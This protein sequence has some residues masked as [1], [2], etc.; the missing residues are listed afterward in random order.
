[1]DSVPIPCLNCRR[2]VT[3]PGGLVRAARKAETEYIVFCSK[4]CNVVYV[5][6]EGARGQQEEES[7]R[8]SDADF[9]E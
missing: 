5:A 6:T 8:H 7:A 2:L 1:M 9:G 3:V 4:Q